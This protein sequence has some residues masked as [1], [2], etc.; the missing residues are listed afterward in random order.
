ML[1]LD[2]LK[3]STDDLFVEKYWLQA[4]PLWDAYADDVSDAV[5]AGHEFN[6]ACL[7]IACDLKT[8]ATFFVWP[9]W[10]SVEC[11][12]E[13]EYVQP[14]SQTGC[15]PDG[16]GGYYVRRFNKFRG[17]GSFA[18]YLIQDG[19]VSKFA[20]SEDE[21]VCEA[22]SI[23]DLV[24]GAFHSQYFDAD[25]RLLSGKEVSE[26]NPGFVFEQ[27][28]YEVANSWGSFRGSESGALLPNE[29]EGGWAHNKFIEEV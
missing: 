7:L 20:S 21:Y 11:S 5:Q 28:D 12:K 23:D 2:C 16:R 17:Y 14:D 18:G 24:W 29:A 10:S 6:Y 26:A 27:P 19:V 1:D 22:W 8:K 25:N 9:T 3:A 15:T 4:E 13:D